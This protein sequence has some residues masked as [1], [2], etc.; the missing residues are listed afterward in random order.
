MKLKPIILA[1]FIVCSLSPVSAIDDYLHIK[2]ADGWVVFNLNKADRLTFSGG[3]MNVLD[4]SGNTVTTI[5]QTDL[6]KAHF[7]N[8][9]ESTSVISVIA[10][11]PTFTFDAKSKTIK[12]A[13]DGLFEI[14]SVDGKTLVSIPEAKKGENISVEDMEEGIVI[15]KSGNYTLKTIVK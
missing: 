2:T 9:P 15:M 8:T 1:A 11:E 10:E 3:K 5:S 12:I 7:S 6:E 14:F 13:S 4:A